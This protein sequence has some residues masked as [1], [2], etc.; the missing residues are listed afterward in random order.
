VE[1]GG[2]A[3]PLNALERAADHY[4]SVQRL[5]LVK[6]SQNKKYIM[7]ACL[8]IGCRDIGFAPGTTEIA[9]FMQL[10]SK[11]TAKGTNFVRGLEADGLV[12]MDVN[13]DPCKAEIMTFFVYLGFDGAGFAVF[14][15]AVYNIVQ[16]AIRNNIA[17]NS[18]SRSKVAGAMYAVLRRCENK[19]LLPKPPNLQEFCLAIKIRRNTVERVLVQLEAYHSYFV[20]CYEAAG[21]SAV[22][23]RS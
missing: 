8:K 4:N 7:A 12:D 1:S 9:S 3:F 13:A 17:P 20:P 18:V 23:G 21:L 15:E 16:T 2:R 11:G 14:R 19:E 22:I 5:L 6:R 10:P